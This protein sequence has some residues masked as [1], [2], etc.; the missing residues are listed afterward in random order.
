MY[1]AP[2]I[3]RHW[4]P[5]IPI[6]SFDKS[7]P[8]VF[9]LGSLPLILWFNSA[10]NKPSVII[11]SCNH[12]GSSLKKATINNNCLI[13]PNHNLK[14]NS[15]YNFGTTFINNQDGFI[16]WSFKPNI[17]SPFQLKSNNNYN[18]K[19]YNNKFYNNNYII[20][21]DL[22]PFILNFI[23]LFSNSND[24]K[25]I[26]GKLFLRNYEKNHRLIFIYPYTFIIKDDNLN[27][28]IKIAIRPIQFSKLKILIS[29]NS[30]YLSYY[31][32]KIMNKIASY[33]NDFKFKYNFILKNNYNPML[34][35]I[36][37]YY[38]NNYMDL[39]NDITIYN[40]LLNSKFY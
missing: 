36:Y 34:D 32:I 14:H 38:K 25:F 6:N 5:I 15:S 26:S 22:I 27:T 40:F 3:F 31:Y 12:L 33:H 28:I 30:S 20:K 21:S 18:N 29:T 10:L 23:Y 16:W 1:I 7:K 2:Q 17:K 19:F 37:N 35:K 13:C 11:N 39:N 9:N 8:F 24:Y 4:T